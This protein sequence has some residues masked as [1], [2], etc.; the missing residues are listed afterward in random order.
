MSIFRILIPVT[1][2]ISAVLGPL[3]GKNFN[4]LIACANNALM[5]QQTIEEKDIDLPTEIY[6]QLSGEIYSVTGCGP[7]SAAMVLS[8]EKAIEITKDEAVTEAYAK[9]YYYFAGENFTSGRG[10]TLEN[11]QSFMG[12]YGVETEIDHLWYDSAAG[13]VSKVNSKLYAG[14]RVII[15][16]YSDH[17]FLHYSVIYAKEYRNGTNNYKVA[18][19]WGG[20]ELTWTED[21][22]VEVLNKVSGWDASTF[23]GQVKGIL[24]IR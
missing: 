21:K 2:F 10:V 5:I 19:P 8:A 23:E 1:V 7:T 12:E 13:I 15:G 18:D 9:G 20:N 4:K 11:I 22:L 3:Q 17:G 16:Y 6:D 14:H 24:W